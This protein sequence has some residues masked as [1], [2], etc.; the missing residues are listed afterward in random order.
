MDKE[1]LKKHLEAAK[2]FLENQKVSKQIQE[3]SKKAEAPEF[4]DTP[5]EAQ[6]ISS[7]LASLQKMQNT[8]KE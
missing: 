6:K 3:L 4:W 7:Q 2:D 8:W 1:V 5:K